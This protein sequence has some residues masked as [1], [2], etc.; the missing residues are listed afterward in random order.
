MAVIIVAMLF[1]GV[2]MVTT[3]ST[4]HTWL[5]DLHKPLGVAVLVLALVRLAVRMRRGAPPLP[6]DMPSLQKGVAH[7]SHIALYG[8]MIAMP[9]LGWAMV[10]AGGYPVTL[11][12]GV[13]LPPI[14]PADAWWFARLHLAHTVLAYVLFATVLGHLGAALF[15]GLIRRDGV[16]ESM[17]TG[18]R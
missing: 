1:V 13:H 17:T 7:L 3:V 6:D 5:V 2:G 14:A 4:R 11:F 10:S 15:H 8:L 9:L 12:G 18:A 16:L